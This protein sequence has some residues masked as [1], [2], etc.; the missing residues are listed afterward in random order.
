MNDC[1]AT[2]LFRVCGSL[3]RVRIENYELFGSSA[4][5]SLRHKSVAL[6]TTAALPAAQRAAHPWPRPMAKRFV[7]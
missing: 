7:R 3:A 5:R 1:E 6:R 4:K 2:A